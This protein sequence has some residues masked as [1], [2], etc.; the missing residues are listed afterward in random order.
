MT[1][2]PRGWTIRQF[3]EAYLSGVGVDEV[4]GATLAMLAAAPDG[5]LIGTPLYDRAGE[6]VESIADVDPASLP[7]Y[8]IPYIVKDNIDV[9]GVE[10]TA[11]CPGFA[12]IAGSDATVVA[13]LRAAGAIVVGKA[14]L[15]Q[16]ATG[17]V[18]T[19]SP[20]GT[21]ENV[22]RPELVP[23]GS[24]CGS[25]VAVALGLVPFSIGTDTA[26]SGRIPAGLNGVVALKPTLGRFSTA[27]IVP[28]VRRVDCPSL[29]ARC[30]D[31]L[32]VAASAMSGTDP[33]DALSRSIVPVRPLRW[34]PRVGVPQ[35]WPG[36]LELDDE[37]GK[38]FGVAVQRLAHL[39]AIIV[40]IDITPALELGEMLYG[41]ALV[42]ERTAA[43]GESVA[44]DVEGLDPTVAAIIAGGTGF[45]AVDAYRGEYRLAELRAACASSWSGV[46]VV[47]LPTASILATLR[48]VRADPFGVNRTL[49]RLTSFVNLA[50]AACVVVP[51]G[52]NIPAGLQLIAPA[53]HDEDLLALG[54]SYTDESLAS[55]PKS[56]AIVVVGAHLDGQPLNHQLTD[57][58]A[59]C[60]T[61]TTTSPHY[62]LHALAGTTPPKPGLRRVGGGEAGASI[63]VEVWS[64]GLTEFGS[65][66]AA[67]PPP[68]CIGSIELADGSWHKGFLCEPWALDGG[69]DITDFGGWRA[70]LSS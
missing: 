51:F 23:G 43:V 2:D 28:A 4:I 57:R 68:L 64:I 32:A 53:W 22:L 37:V 1:V 7:L 31:D 9:A 25:A 55:A 17:L 13:R 12:T 56:C 45:T 8:G 33:L 29:F 50:D 16:F 61:R 21:P 30:I 49:G 18:G 59:W 10:T 27:G 6:E 24:S 14:N 69:L 34:P 20:F 40:P 38:G 46:D 66:V 3:R 35:V 54:Q 67:V 11:G 48:A 39:G 58:G 26:G 65:F 44:G 15:D 42:A 60:R 47:A 52:D 70:Y 63:E 62:R 41:S 5:V 36:D 19:R